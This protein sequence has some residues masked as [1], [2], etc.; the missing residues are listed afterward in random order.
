[1]ESGRQFIRPV[2]MNYPDS[3]KIIKR[4]PTFPSLE[5]VKL[6]VND[7]LENYKVKIESEYLGD[8]E[9]YHARIEKEFIDKIGI[10]VYLFQPSNTNKLTSKIYRL[11]E[12][13]DSMN[14]N[15][16]SEYSYLPAP[17]CKSFRRANYPNNPV[18]YCSPD[19]K[20][21]ILET[22]PNDFISNEGRRFFM[23]EWEF[24]KDEEINITPFFAGN[25]SHD[26][27]LNG[28]SESL[29]TN[30]QN[31]FPELSELEREVFLEIVVFLSNLFA[32]ENSYPI[33]SFLAHSHL[34]SFV[35][36]IRTDVFVYPSV[37][38]DTKTI[39]Y[40]IHPNAVD[41]K[42]ILNRI[43]AMRILKMEYNN[44][45]VKLDYK[46]ERVGLNQNGIIHWH[47]PDEAMNKNFADIIQN[48]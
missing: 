17:L 5:K 27:Y 38:A 2:N 33:T 41:Q 36:P 22:V 14:V 13:S 18:F 34:Y 3:A 1:M 24:R 23:S 46:L 9:E 44:N 26:S 10:L 32:Y 42:M 6:F 20:T 19:P 31:S 29:L 15:L 40:A 47:E 8:I 48:K 30:I 21:A 4:K 39:N 7:F 25:Y 37:K 45:N 12:F 11:R 43:Y 28:I 16:I 35:S